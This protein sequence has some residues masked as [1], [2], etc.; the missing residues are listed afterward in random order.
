MTQASVTDV[1]REAFEAWAKG[2]GFDLTRAA[3]R[4]GK[5]YDDRDTYNAHAGWMAAIESVEL[6]N[7]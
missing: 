3:G 1:Q 2:E 6:E 5:Y 4:F 7:D